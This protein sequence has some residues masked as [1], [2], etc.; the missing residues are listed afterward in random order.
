MFVFDFV[1]SKLLAKIK[2]N[3]NDASIND[4]KA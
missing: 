4:E 1:L 2:N 3:K